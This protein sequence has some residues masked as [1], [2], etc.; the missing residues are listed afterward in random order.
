MKSTS[1]S[2]S[3]WTTSRSCPSV[4]LG[5]TRI[6][7]APPV[8]ASARVRKVSPKVWSEVTPGAM[9][10]ESRSTRG[11]RTVRNR[12]PAATALV[13]RPARN[14]R[15]FTGLSPP[16]PV[17]AG[18]ARDWRR[19]THG[20]RPA[21]R[22]RSTPSRGRRS[23]TPRPGPDPAHEFG[24]GSTSTG[25]SSMRA[26]CSFSHV[27][28]TFSSSAAV[29][30]FSCT[31]RMI[32]SMVR[33]T[34]GRLVGGASDPE[35]ECV[36]SDWHFGELADDAGRIRSAELLANTIDDSQAQDL[37]KR[38]ELERLGRPSTGALRCR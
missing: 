18:G 11:P 13:P 30:P 15:R 28:V 23:P 35:P 1:P 6:V 25:S 24:G 32:P 14:S 20:Q 3:C 33:P 2:W 37:G 38:V 16:V 7:T 34:A 29:G 36:L 4:P 17:S 27:R 31:A 8:A 21:H 26:S 9:E 22:P 19:Q 10:C 12:Q 5:N